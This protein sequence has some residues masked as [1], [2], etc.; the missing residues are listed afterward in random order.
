MIIGIPQPILLIVVLLAV[1]ALPLAAQG[2]NP[3]ASTASAD[4]ARIRTDIRNGAVNSL[5]KYDGYPDLRS[6]DAHQ[7]V[8]LA[9]LE[10][11]NISIVP[12][13]TRIL[14]PKDDNGY[15]KPCCWN[16]EPRVT[17][18]VQKIVDN[19]ESHREHG[20]FVYSLGDEGVTRGC[21]VSP[22]CIAAYRRYLL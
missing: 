15:M 11:K 2:R 10:A 8:I 22:A 14:D 7:T 20:V 4:L 5:W 3:E 9:K 6:L 1:L 12:Y 17:E 16:D 13:S 21:C 19:Q 18:Y